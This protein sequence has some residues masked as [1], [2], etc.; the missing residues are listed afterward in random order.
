MLYY[1]YYINI[2]ILI[3][4]IVTSPSI[5][6]QLISNEKYIASDDGVI[7]MYVNVMGHVESPGLYLVYDGID[8]LTVLSIAGGYKNGANLNKI[9]IYRE[10]GTQEI[11]TLKSILNSTDNNKITL[12]PHDTVY[13]K[14]KTMSKIFNSSN[15]PTIVLSILNLALTIDRTD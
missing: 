5:N 13:I 4:F 3:S 6:N 14:Q 12:N 8:I 9:T 11:V 15:I 7:R 10:D 2:L 1:K